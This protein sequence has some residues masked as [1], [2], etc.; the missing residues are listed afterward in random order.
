VSAARRLLGVRAW[1]AQH[2][3]VT[4]ARAPPSTAADASVNSAIV[5]ACQYARLVWLLLHDARNVEEQKDALRAAMAVIG[6]GPVTI[7]RRARRVF[8]NGKALPDALAAGPELG[9]QMVAHGVRIIEI[10]A[11]ATPADLLGTARILST[12][13]TSGDGGAGAKKHLEVVKPASIRFAFEDASLAPKLDDKLADPT[14]L[15]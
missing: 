15:P 6:Q 14:P 12:P 4:D 13:G 5:F 3:S 9:I 8:A 1:T 11:N 7:A 2:A 10:A